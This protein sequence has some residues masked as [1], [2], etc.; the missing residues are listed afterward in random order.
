MRSILASQR[1]IVTSMS[2]GALVASHTLATASAIEYGID[3]HGAAKDVVTEGSPNND[4][5]DKVG[6]SKYQ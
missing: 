6:L 2:H 3:V 4:G 1:F 5:K